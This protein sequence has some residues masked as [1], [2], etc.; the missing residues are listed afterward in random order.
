[1]L[2]YIFVMLHIKF[3]SLKLWQCCHTHLV[4]VLIICN[5][6]I[7]TLAQAYTLHSKSFVHQVVL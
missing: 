3:L 5:K 1:M 6:L 4:T 2:T 7:T